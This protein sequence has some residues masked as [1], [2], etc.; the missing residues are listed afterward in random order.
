MQENTAAETVTEVVDTVTETA[1]AEDTAGQPTED[2]PVE[3]TTGTEEPTAEESGE[4]APEGED[5]EIDNTLYV[6]Q[7]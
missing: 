7:I 4:G 5:G 3:D 6:A 1:P 2:A